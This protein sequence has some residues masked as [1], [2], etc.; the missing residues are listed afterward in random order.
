MFRL[1]VKG[2]QT[3]VNIN[4]DKFY[5]L[6]E[7]VCIEQNKE[8]VKEWLRKTLN[9]IPGYTGTA[10][11]TLVPVGR[12]T[13]TIIS[14]FGPGGPSGNQKKAKYKKYIRYGGHIIRAGFH[15]GKNYASAAIGT[16]REGNKI[17]NTF[18]FTNTLPYIARNDISGPPPNFIMPS[19]PP[20]YS[21]GKGAAAWQNYIR[22]I[23]PTKLPTL[24]QFI[25]VKRIRVR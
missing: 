7:K 8:A 10:R 25:K 14:R 13:N 5:T 21:H 9:N 2:T 16:K 12:L 18:T 24:S 11:G 6:L 3:T 19:N 17:I 20:W 1:R 4:L 23:I 15:H 22:T